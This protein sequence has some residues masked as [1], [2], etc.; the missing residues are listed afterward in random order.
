MRCL[1]VAVIAVILG[2]AWKGSTARAEPSPA[3]AAVLAPQS[4]AE[5]YFELGGASGL[6][7]GIYTA[8]AAELGYRPGGGS[9]SIHAV[10]QSG[11]V[12][13]FGP[14]DE[15]VTS[16]GYLALRAGVEERGCE[17]RGVWCAFA[18]TDVGYLHQY[19]MTKSEHQDERVAIIVPRVGLDAG[20]SA[21]RVRVGFETSIARH[22]LETMGLAAGIAFNW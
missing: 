2:I 1:V 10:I 7:I 15:S 4:P 14:F 9:L 6:G 21:V 17:R 16:S 22:N 5:F 8:G 13:L 3:P 18:S 11:S 20:G 12:P 19:A